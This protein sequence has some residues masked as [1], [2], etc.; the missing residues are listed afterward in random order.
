MEE[1]VSKFKSVVEVEQQN[2]GPQQKIPLAENENPTIRS[3]QEQ[4]MDKATKRQKGA[5]GQ[6]I[7]VGANTG[8][9]A[10]EKPPI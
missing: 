3:N 1:S 10:C 4:G 5:E 6:N 8:A 9:E 2:S 7:A